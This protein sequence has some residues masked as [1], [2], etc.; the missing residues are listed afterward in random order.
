MGFLH[1]TMIIVMLKVDNYYDIIEEIIK[2][3]DNFSL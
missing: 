3:N 2:F 1:S